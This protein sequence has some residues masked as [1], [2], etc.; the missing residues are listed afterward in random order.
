MGL[1]DRNPDDIIR[2]YRPEEEVFSEDSLSSFS[3]KPVT[4][5]H[6]PE[7]VN[8]ANYK[9]YSVGH[10]SADVVRD[11]M[12]AATELTVMDLQSIK[13]IESGKS[14]LSNGYTSDIEWTE[15]ISP[16]GEQYDAIQRNIKGNH[17]AIVKRGRAGF[18]CRVADNLPNK[19]AEANMAKVTIDGVD[20]EMPDQAAQAVGKLQA[21]LTDTEEKISDKEE[22]L[23]KKEADAEEAEKKAKAAEDESKAKLDDALSK[24]PS[25]ET[26]DKLVAARSTLVDSVRKILPDF[27]F[28]GKDADTIRKEAVAAKCDNVQMDSVSTDYIQAR[29]DMLVEAINGNSQANL[30]QA[31]TDTVVTDKSGETVDNRPADV[32]AREKFMADSQ[33]AWKT[34]VTK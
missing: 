9:M 8:A 5:N 24:V 11:G 12:F 2:V 31:F 1:T 16:E 4:N 17:I 21:K 27:E 30:D 29:F 3:N 32:I 23:A 15:G 19:G 10:S 20:F 22:E 6:P 13:D 14:E 33:D 7:L 25:T 28:V 34:G 26:I 18:A